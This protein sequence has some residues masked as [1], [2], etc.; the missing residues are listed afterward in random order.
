MGS[1]DTASLGIRPMT[2]SMAYEEVVDMEVNT[3]DGSDIKCLIVSVVNFIY[4]SGAV[5]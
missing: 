4:D 2:V 5:T 3:D 1:Y